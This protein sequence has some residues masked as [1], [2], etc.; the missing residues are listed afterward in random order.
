MYMSAMVTQGLVLRET[1]TKES[2]KILTLLTPDLGKVSVIARG[3]RQKR[4]KYAASAQP[5][6]Y[7]EWTLYQRGD[8]HYAREGSPLELFSGLQKNLEAFYLGFCFAELTEA[9]ALEDVP[10]Q[11]IL[12]HL[13]NGLYALSALQK[14]PELVRPAFILRLLCLAG[15]EPLAEACAYCGSPEPE[16]PMLDVVQGVLRCRRCGSGESG[17]SR[18]LCPASL[19]AL[20]HIVY[21]DVKRIYSFQLTPEPLRRLTDAVETLLTVQLE[22][23]FSTLE[24]YKNLQK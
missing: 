4:C 18:P 17:Y 23:S 24:A 15:Y 20:R 3:A 12:R 21:G 2:D 9:V 19:K 6:V 13:L 11:D 5:L 1:A 22:R 8:W 14:P 10:C 16:E 7:S